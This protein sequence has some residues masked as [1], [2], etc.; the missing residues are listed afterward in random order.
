MP[1]EISDRLD[2]VAKISV[3]IEDRDLIVS[4]SDDRSGRIHL[5]LCEPGQL[6]PPRYPE[7]YNGNIPSNNLA[8]LREFNKVNLDGYVFRLTHSQIAW[9]DGAA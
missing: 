9:I 3:L 8:A 4:S 7:C 2:K 5:F 1:L 6:H